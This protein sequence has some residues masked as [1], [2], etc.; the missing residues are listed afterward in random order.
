[1]TT[2][3]NNATGNLTAV[4]DHGAVRTDYGYD[5]GGERILAD[6][7]TNTTITLGGLYERTV[8]NATGTKTTETSY[9]PGPGGTH[10]MRIDGT[11]KYLFRDHLDTVIATWDPATNNVTHHGYHPYGTRRINTAASGTA[12][13]YTGQ[14]HDPT[15]LSYYHARY[16]DPYTGR[17]TGP[18]TIIP[19]AANPQNLNRYAYVNG[20]PIRF[21]DPTGHCVFD[22]PCP[23]DEIGDFAAG[24]GQGLRDTLEGIIGIILHPIETLEGLRDCIRDPVACGEALIDDFIGRCETKGIANCAGYITFDALLTAFTGGWGAA[25]V[26]P[27]IRRI[28]SARRNTPDLPNGT[29]ITPIVTS[30]LAR[31]GDDIAPSGWVRRT[32]DNGKGTVWQ[33]P[34][35]T[36]NTD[37]FRIMEPTELYPNGYSVF[38]NRHG[39]PINLA[40]KPGTRFETHIPLKADGTV[41]VPGGW[42]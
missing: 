33:K 20:N 30:G 10:A 18:D 41:R 21:N 8:A 38:Y 1:M 19:N 17:F 29:T 14:R 32:V 28:K 13:G 40:G 5:T 7:G 2:A 24:L 37:M 12:H 16:Y 4:V 31:L 27:K 23:A 22:L 25:K 6:D 26:I 11:V 35:A 34:G 3:V 42:P 9:Y 36:K 39:Q 15:G